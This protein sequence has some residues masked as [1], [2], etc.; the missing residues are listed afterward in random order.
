MNRRDFLKNLTAGAAII[1]APA[2][3][4]ADIIMPVKQLVL[5]EAKELIVPA[6]A[7]PMDGK[8]VYVRLFVSN[9]DGTWSESPDE[10]QHVD[11]KWNSPVIDWDK[12]R[13]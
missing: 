8:E 12:D 13:A 9:D 3:V 10:I 7:Y 11:A 5:P 6:L 4:S 2:I 1:T